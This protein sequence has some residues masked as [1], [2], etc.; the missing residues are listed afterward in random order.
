M[1][2]A[3]ETPYTIFFS[4]DP[5]KNILTI[6]ISTRGNYPTLGLILDNNKLIGNWVTLIE[7]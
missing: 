5:Y 2:I 4:V 6:N 3:I 1:I 7:F